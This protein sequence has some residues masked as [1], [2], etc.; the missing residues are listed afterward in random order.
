M[1]GI[2]SL[3]VLALLV[4]GT[5]LGL[6]ETVETHALLRDEETIE[7]RVTTGSW[8]P[9]AATVDIDPDTLNPDSQGNHV[10]AYIELPDGYDVADIDVGTVTLRV[11]GEEDSVPAE[12]SPTEVGD[13]D[14]DGIPDAMVKF[15]RQTVLDLIDGTTGDVT[16]VVS[17]ELSGGATFEGSDTVAL[18]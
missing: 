17:G 15:D 1:N 3:L 6:W 9:I 8:G 11:E 4:T 13:H 5:A 7:F 12:L 16:F 14:E 2:L 10:M 18:L